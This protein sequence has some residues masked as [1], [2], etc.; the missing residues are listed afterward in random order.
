MV[1]FLEHEGRTSERT[2][3]GLKPLQ[4]LL[5]RGWKKH[6]R[7]AVLHVISR[8]QCAAVH[9]RIWAVDSMNGR[10]RLKAEDER[11]LGAPNAKERGS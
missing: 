6:V 7:S 1:L 9:T 4:I 3:T 2:T 8:A 5:P 11:L 10:V